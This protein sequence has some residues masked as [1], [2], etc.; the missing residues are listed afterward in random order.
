MNDETQTEIQVEA[1]DNREITQPEQVLSAG[2]AGPAGFLSQINERFDD[3]CQWMNEANRIAQDRERVIDRLHQENQQLRGGELQQA[4][5]P[6]FRDL[7]RLHDDLLQTSQ[8]YLARAEA[9]DTE[10]ARDFQSYSDAVTDILYRYGVERYET[11]VGAPFNSKEHRALAVV[12]TT[13][14]NLDRGI[15]KVIRFGFRTET[16]IV[17]LLEAEVFRIGGE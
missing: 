13:D 15:A 6:V 7:I 12:P 8:R 3:L 9:S 1:A 10:A 2:P 16:R 14:E 17:R 5:A 4:M 11:D